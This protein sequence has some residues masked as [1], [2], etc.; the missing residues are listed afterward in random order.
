MAFGSC[1]KHDHAQ[2]L[3]EAI[4]GAEPQVWA[5]L[6][7]NVYV[8]K[9]VKPGSQRF[10]WLG[11]QAM[12]QAYQEQLAHAGYAA[13]RARAAV[14]GTYDD[15]DYGLNNAGAELEHKDL[16]AQLALDF[17]GEPAGSERRQQVASRGDIHAAYTYGPPGRRTRLILLDTR[18]SREALPDVDLVTKR[19]LEGLETPGDVLGEEQWAWLEAQLTHEPRANLTIIGSSVPVLPGL[20]AFLMGADLCEGWHRFPVARARLLRLLARTGTT[21]VIFLGGDY[22]FGLIDEWDAQCSPLGYP[23][24]DVVSS[25]M[26]HA[27]MDVLPFKGS[28]LWR[29]FVTGKQCPSRAIG[30]PFERPLYLDLNWGMVEVDWH[31]AG[32]AMVS[33]SV[34][35]ESGE[36]VLRRAMRLAELA[37]PAGFD[38]EAASDRRGGRFDAVSGE[39]RLEEHT[40]GWRRYT[41]FLY[42]LVAVGAAALTSGWG[43][44][45]AAAAAA[46]LVATKVI[47]TRRSAGRVKME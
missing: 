4:V 13:L 20:S 26:T 41:L 10:E 47:R 6:G 38:A 35:D 12:R 25:G 27:V 9:K 37:P 29:W 1:S 46:A 8:D 24:L 5:W 23:T 19:G 3:W 43:S 40:A 21:G 32:G 36:A 33:V 11:E 42:V 14:V 30:L 16:G 2:P 44:A 31:A 17:L 34:R 18:Y 7:D 45:A 15:H 22:H 39:C 28:R